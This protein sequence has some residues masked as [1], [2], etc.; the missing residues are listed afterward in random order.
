MK[1]FHAKCCAWASHLCSRH[2]RMK[3]LGQKGW[4]VVI[5]TTRTRNHWG[6]GGTSSDREN[7]KWLNFVVYHQLQCSIF[8]AIALWD[9]EPEGG[10][11]EANIILAEQQEINSIP[12]LHFCGLTHSQH[13]SNGLA[14]AHTC[15]TMHC[16]PL[17]YNIMEWL[18][19]YLLLTSTVMSV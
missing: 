18:V 17:V 1:Y 5:K 12:Q 16:I 15:P 3:K 9:S 6:K 13:Q 14:P 10:L 7:C 8:R 4:T 11:T 19:S 2:G